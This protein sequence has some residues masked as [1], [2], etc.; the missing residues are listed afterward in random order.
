MIALLLLKKIVSLF[1]IMFM[2]TAIVKLKFLK[3]E[4]SKVVSTLI[5]W[6]IVPCAII[7]AYQVDFSEEVKQGFMLAILAAVI[8]N[9]GM[10]IAMTIVSRVL[11]LDVIEFLSVPYTNC[12]NLM[13]PLVVAM[14]GQ[15]WVIYCMPF[16]AC[17]QILI[18]SHMKSVI[19]GEKGIDVKKIVKNI[20]MIA[21]VIG[22]MMFWFQI[23][24][25]AIGLDIVRTMGDMLGAMSMI[26]T[27]MLLANVDLKKVFTYKRTIFVTV[28]RLII[29][30]FAALVFLKFGPLKY[31]IPNGSSVLLIT[32]LAAAAPSAATLTQVALIYDADAEY[33][34]SINVVTTL[35][36][37]VTM[38]LMVALYQ[39]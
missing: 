11:K 16:V 13:I 8:I 24:L 17:Q 6:I 28:L 33:A 4:D 7:N 20:N 9:A 19:C 35:L 36:C 22:L 25:P 21:I 15:E 30:P 1:I 18:W 3:A 39:M 26:L 34:N 29:V 37:I 12:G 23:K 5:L 32:L 38:P 27:G 10:V 14:L 2:G 31:M